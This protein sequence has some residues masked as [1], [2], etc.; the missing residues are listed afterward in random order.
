MH[1]VLAGR[2]P[3]SFGLG[4]LR[5]GQMLAVTEAELALTESELAALWEA[6]GGA[7][8]AATLRRVRE[9]TEGWVTGVILAAQAGDADFQRR[10]D[11]EQ[12]FDYL[13]EE[14]LAA[15]PREVQDFL[16]QTAMLE[17]FSPE[18]A[19]AIDRPRRPADLS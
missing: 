18:L 11:S 9:R 16:L 1:L 2:A 8:D 4:K 13:A 12:L 10:A 17:R 7:G 3:L 19:C 6:G 5:A 15:Q 14:V